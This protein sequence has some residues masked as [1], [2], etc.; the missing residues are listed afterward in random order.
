LDSVSSLI[1]LTYERTYEGELAMRLEAIASKGDADKI[2][3][4]PEINDSNGYY[5][6]ITVNTLYK[7]IKNNNSYKNEDIAAFEQ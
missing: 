1:G 4:K 5:G 6:L 2:S 7:L 3:I